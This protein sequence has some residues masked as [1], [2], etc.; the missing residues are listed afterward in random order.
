MVI[1]TVITKKAKL[2]MEIFTKE[3][4]AKRDLG[5]L[6]SPVDRAHMKRP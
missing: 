5:N 6:T 3:S 2:E 4:V 1:V